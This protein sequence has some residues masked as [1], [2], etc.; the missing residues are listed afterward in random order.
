MSSRTPDDS[1]PPS[2]TE[3]ALVALVMGTVGLVG[4]P[5][6]PEADRSG[7]V[8]E[9]VK[10]VDMLRGAIAA[11]AGD[12]G[13]FPGYDVTDGEL[14]EETLVRQLT[15]RTGPLGRSRVAP[16]A[17]HQFGPYLW[18]LP[19]NP[20]NQLANVRIVGDHE[21]FP[22]VPDGSTGWIFRPATGELRANTTGVLPGTDDRIYDL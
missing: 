6:K 20:F 5:R 18:E 3:Y 17:P 4:I 9:L 19:A 16:W 7:P 22:A 10:S 15:E 13:V 21:P 1:R 8:R 14:S 12:H 2:L 11:Y